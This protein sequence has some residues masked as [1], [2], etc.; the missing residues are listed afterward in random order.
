[1]IQ[2]DAS[3]NPGNSGGPLL[4]INGDL[5]GINTAIYSKAQG[6][7][8]A[9]PINRA[10]RVISDLIL[11]GEVHT[12]WT[13]IWVQDLD[14]GLARYLKA[15]I[16]QGVLI[17]DIDRNSPAEKAGLRPGDIITNVGGRR[18]SSRDEFHAVI[19]DFSVGTRIPIT[20]WREG[21]EQTVRI[22]AKSFPEN[23]AEELAYKLLGVQ[24]ADLSLT[25]RYR[26]HISASEGVVLTRLKPGSYLE[27][28][29]ARPGDVIRQ[30]NEVVIKTVDDFKKAVVKY[31]ERNSLVILIQR[32]RYQY[33]VAVKI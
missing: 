23:L 16:D 8:F 18:V 26:F 13:G 19:R 15:P 24:V 2:T 12:A 11:Y 7:G 32:G 3:I 1:F 5:I 21:G 27:R 33:F 4:N 6:I 30:V 22:E 17:T 14:R 25:R 20:F 29:G 28:I 9:I 10:K 31:R